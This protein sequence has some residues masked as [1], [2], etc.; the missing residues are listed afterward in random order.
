MNLREKVEKIAATHDTHRA[1][2]D[3]C[4]IIA[5]Q[6]ARLALEHAVE[7]CKVQ[8][9]KWPKGGFGDAIC[10][11]NIAAIRAEAKT[12]GADAT[13]RL[14]ALNDYDNTVAGKLRQQLNEMQAIRSAA[15]A[16]RAAAQE[17]RCTYPDCSC[18]GPGD[19]GGC[20]MT[21]PA[22]AEPQPKEGDGK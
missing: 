8:Q 10:A 15:Q 19:D 20:G 11:E 2:K 5:R 3:C 22:Q 4:R 16:E 7:V 1:H 9:D 12:L 14:A 21:A 18:D 17:P 13:T 6:A